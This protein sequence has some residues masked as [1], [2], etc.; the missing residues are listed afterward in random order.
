MARDRI[1]SFMK[2]LNLK[3]ILHEPVLLYVLIGIAFYVL[4]SLYIN[5]RP[6]ERKRIE[7]TMEQMEQMATQFTASW[8]RPPTESEFQGLMDNH[9][10]N[11]VYYREALILG[12]EKND[13]VIQNRLRQKL[14]LLMDNMASVNV[15]SE[16]ML[17]T[18][19]QENADDFKRDYEVSFM[20]V[21]VNPE[22]HPDPEQEA[23]DL[24]NRLYAGANPEDLG[25]RTLVGYEF[26]YYTQT[27]VGRQFG[28]D[29]AQE[30]ALARHGE[31]TGPIFSGLGVHLVKIFNFKEGIMPD[32]SEIRNI[33]EREWMARQKTKMKDAAYEKLLEGYDVIIEEGAARE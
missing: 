29:F 23:R 27:D 14:E 26:P 19:L 20:Q 32:L 8:L 28:G 4:H 18:F 2:K 6:A 7:V 11:E 16:Q 3:R 10:R 31:W 13:Q 9:V 15:P 30:L 22:N 1:L 33:V 5:L 17:A 25:D 12:L 24:L 21:Y